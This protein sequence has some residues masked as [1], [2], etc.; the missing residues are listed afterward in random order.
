MS[1]KRYIDSELHRKIIIFFHENPACVDSP[2]G[3]ATWVGSTRE[4][5]KKALDDLKQAGVLNSI[6]TSSA[7]GY[8]YTQDK[9]IRK[10]IQVL[11]GKYR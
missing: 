2:R 5:T 11:I 10:K 8:S 3:I 4:K 7:S 6:A 1:L 9:K